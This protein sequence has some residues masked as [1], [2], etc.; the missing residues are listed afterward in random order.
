MARLELE[1][2]PEEARILRGA[3]LTARATELGDSTGAGFGIP[4]AMDPTLPG[5][6]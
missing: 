5:R 3:L 2:D 1:L 4:P 6:S